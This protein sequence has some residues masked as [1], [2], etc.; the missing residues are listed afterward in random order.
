MDQDLDLMKQLLMLN[1]QIEE[2]KWRKRYSDKTPLVSSCELN[3]SDYGITEYDTDN[4]TP[5]Q[6]FSDLHDKYP[7][8]S[9]LSL[10]KDDTPSSSCDLLDGNAE[11]GRVTFKTPLC[12]KTQSSNHKGLNASRQH[13]CQRG[14]EEQACRDLSVQS[15]Y[16]AGLNVNGSGDDDTLK[17]MDHSEQQSFDSG[18]NEGDQEQTEL[19]LLQKRIAS[20]HEQ[21]RKLITGSHKVTTL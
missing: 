4:N 5:Q 1:D 20:L 19:L 7:S 14:Q 8:P 2:L 10:C 17:K 13:S 3:S 16:P 11:K 15:A 6:S 9:S 18:F 21:H 12:T